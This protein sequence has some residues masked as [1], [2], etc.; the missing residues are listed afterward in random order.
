MIELI[1]L[2]VG[3]RL[4]LLGGITAEIIEKIDDE[5]VRVRL[6]TVPEEKGR[7]GDRAAF[8]ESQEPGADLAESLGAALEGFRQGLQAHGVAAGRRLRIAVHL[9]RYGVECRQR[10]GGVT[11]LAGA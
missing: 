6:L 5:W 2:P 8:V 3:A 11:F 10:F 4:S 7:P 1:A 9:R